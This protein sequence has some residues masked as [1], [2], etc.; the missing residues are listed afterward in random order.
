MHNPKKNLPNKKS[1]D[2]SIVADFLIEDFRFT[3]SYLS[4]LDKLFIEERKRYESAY[5]FH[6]TKVEELSN[7][8]NLKMAVYK[9]GDL[10]DDGYPIVPLNADEFEKDDILYIEQMIEPII[11]T[12]DGKVIRQGTAILTR[13]KN[14]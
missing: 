12:T 1:D 2:L 9:R 14:I 13:E 7:K 11:L 4:I 3:R 10:Y 5:N 6:G 8:F